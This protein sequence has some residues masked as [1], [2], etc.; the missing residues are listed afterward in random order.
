MLL[1]MPEL[2]ITNIALFIIKIFVIR[3]VRLSM[4][5]QIALSNSFSANIA[6]ILLSIVFRVQVSPIF[7]HG[8][9]TVIALLTA[10]HKI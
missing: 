5:L 2:L 7:S 1:E 3:I 6:N 4:L 8:D 10:N 9:E